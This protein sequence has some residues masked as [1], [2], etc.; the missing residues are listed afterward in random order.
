[1]KERRPVALRVLRAFCQ[2]ERG[3]EAEGDLMEAFE[4]WT[5]SYGRLRASLR[6]WLEVLRLAVGKE[7][8]PG[9]GTGGRRS[10]KGS[11]FRD[12][13]Q[14]LG[15]AFRRLLRSPGPTAVAVVILGLGIGGNTAIFT[16]ADAL[17]LEAPPL[18]AEPQELVALQ[19]DYEEFGY[20]D[21]LYYREHGGAFQDVMAFSGFPG[22]RGMTTKSGGE[23]TVGSGNDLVQARAW[24]VSANYFQLLGVPLLHGSGFTGR[25]GEPLAGGPEVVLSHGFWQRHL[26]GV[27]VAP[28]QSITLNGVPFR[29]AGITPSGFRG[30]NPTDQLPDLFLPIMA[31]EALVPGFNEGMVRY[32]PSGEPQGG[33]YLR[34]VGRLRRD[35]SPTRVRVEMDALQR[36]WEAEFTD[37]AKAVYGDTYEV[38]IRPEF[39]LSRGE[40]RQMRRMLTFLWFVVGSVLLVACTNLAIL[41]LARGAGREREMGIRASLGAGKGRLMR[42]LLTE[43]LILAL[44][45]GT[46][47]V[48]VA[49][50]TTDAMASVLPLAIAFDLA[51]DPTVVAFTLVLSILAALLFGSA[52]AVLLSRVNVAGVLHRAGQLRGRAFFRG[53]MVAVQTALSVVLLVLAGLFLRSLQEARAVDLGFE[54]PNRLLM[55]VRLDNHGYSEEEGRDFLAR[56]L[57][58]I[59]AVPGVEAVTAANRMPFRPRN[60]W[61]FVIPGTDYAVNGLFAGFNMVAPDYFQVMGIPVLT[62]RILDARDGPQSPWSVVVNRLFADRMWPGENPVGKTLTFAMEGEWTVVGVVETSTYW[63]LGEDPVPFVFFPIEQLFSTRMTFHVATRLEPMTVAGAV[64]GAMRRVDPNL[65]IDVTTVQ[66]LLDEQLS[67]FR[68]WS[69]FVALFSTV[70]LLL[71]MVGLYGVQSFLVTRRTREMGIRIALGEGRASLVARVAVGGL[72]MAGAGALVGLCAAL[73]GGRLAESFL[74]GV[75]TRDPWVFGGVAGILLTTCLVASVLPAVRASRVNPMEAL[76]RE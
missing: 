29:I 72:A 65:A 14:D 28:S 16:I 49:F 58:G 7:L 27:P 13:A 2:G 41:M 30:V 34:L 40:A 37:W 5:G 53:G 10:P 39:H 70:A 23:L 43:S 15:Y 52:P 54:T 74:F 11:V 33:R 42:Q 36:R 8:R 32:S 61:D 73:A 17:F 38:S 1:M 6:V 71:A 50:L 63:R 67:S 68:I 64:E 21:F 75:S 20:Y 44:V 60:S 22:T 25:V 3:E 9:R 57:E 4:E 55:S 76:N 69:R 45:G 56:A 24:V 26:G 18:L 12:G 48:G 19:A 46:L 59:G 51:P 31:V 66:A 47:G 35:L 62:G